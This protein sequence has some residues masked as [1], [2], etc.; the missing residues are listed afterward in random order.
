MV[1][2]DVRSNDR[3]AIFGQTGSGKTF[4][5]R[6]LLARVR[7]LVVL[8]PKGMLRGAA[9]GWRLEEWSPAT[10]RRLLEGEPVRVRIP[11]PL[12]RDWEPYLWDI[13]EA[14]NC[15]LYI[16][17]MY[18]VVPIGRRPPDPLNAIYT[19]GRELGLGVVAVSQRPVWVPREMVSESTWFFGFRLMLEDDRKS[20]AD[21]MGPA[22]LDRIRDRYGFWTFNAEWEEPIYTPQLEIVRQRGA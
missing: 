6:Y 11:Y 15:V 22:V 7:R 8:D 21:I 16:D 5:S 14:G 18:G 1:G 3:T 20:L 17:E 2:I 12:D 9:D 10:R 13:Y 19:R 4:L